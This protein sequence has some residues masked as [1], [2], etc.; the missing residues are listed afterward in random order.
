MDFAVPLVP[1]DLLSLLRGP[2][3]SA[4][5]AVSSST[6]LVQSMNK[7]RHWGMLDAVPDLDTPYADKRPQAVWRGSPSGVWTRE[8]FGSSPRHLLYERWGKVPSTAMV[9]VGISAEADW[10]GLRA[11]EDAR[12]LV[13][14][15]VLKP[16]L[17]RRQQL[18]SRYLVVVEGVDVASGRA[19][20]LSSQ[21]VVVMPRPT[22]ETW[23]MEGL[24]EPWVHY[25][26]LEDDASDLASQ[27]AWCEARRDGACRRIAEAGRA[28]MERL[29]ADPA[30]ERSLEI[31]VVREFVRSHARAL[32]A[33]AAYRAALDRAAAI[34]ELA[35]DAVGLGGGG[36]VGRP[37]LLGGWDLAALE[38][39]VV[40]RLAAGADRVV[41]FLPGA[42]AA[43]V[44][45]M[46][47]AAQARRE[48]ES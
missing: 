7:S 40:A 21:S 36:G 3:L 32:A 26:P 9:D 10:G 47:A 28:W 11:G 17:S 38:A 46:V 39:D 19:W 16:D 2:A 22:R 15:I 18:R 30:A 44:A 42:P 13:L 48:G 1:G 8:G 14:D 24:L 4:T 41:E 31:R 34:R 12:P 33:R 35:A 25:L 6:A 5:R 20:A 45:A 43:N 29:T 23:I 37:S 27:V